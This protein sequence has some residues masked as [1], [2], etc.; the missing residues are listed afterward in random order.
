LRQGVGCPCPWFLGSLRLARS[1]RL[2]GGEGG[3]PY[4]RAFEP[5][6]KEEG[7]DGERSEKPDVV[8]TEVD[9][10]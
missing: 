8:D 6:D 7:P 4:W 10:G 9:V 5:G 3:A 2:P 1:L